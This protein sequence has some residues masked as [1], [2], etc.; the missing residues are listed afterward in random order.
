MGE[1]REYEG[2]VGGRSLDREEEDE[3]V[4]HHHRTTAAVAD[5]YSHDTPD[6]TRPW[7]RRFYRSPFYT[8]YPNISFPLMQALEV[9]SG[10]GLDV[11]YSFPF[12][13]DN[14]AFS[15]VGLFEVTVLSEVRI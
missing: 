7:W 3:E 13:I 14:G 11:P 12:V 6:Y 5:G 8:N 4:F 15:S 2:G 1:E 10:T 9:A